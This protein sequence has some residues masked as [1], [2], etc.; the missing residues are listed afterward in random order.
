MVEVNSREA[1]LVEYNSVMVQKYLVCFLFHKKK[2]SGSD[3]KARSVRVALE[4]NFS[5]FKCRSPY[6][7]SKFWW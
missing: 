6:F 4:H 5:R 7:D 2:S 1:I 3:V